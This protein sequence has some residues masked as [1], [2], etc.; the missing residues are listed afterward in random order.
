[1]SAAQ[2]PSDNVSPPT[3][4]SRSVPPFLDL[5]WDDF[6][7]LCRDIALTSGCR[8]VRRHGK[9]GQ[10]QDGIDFHGVDLE[11][12]RIAWQC[13]R[14]GKFGAS[15]L[16]RAVGDFAE[17]PTARQYASFVICIACEGNDRNLQDELTSLRELHQFKI[18]LWDS[19]FLTTKLVRL[20]DLLQ[21][22]F[23]EHWTE[24]LIASAATARVRLN[25][26]ALL[27]GPV[28]A[29]G[30]TSKA[31]QADRL[32]ES[33]PA[34]AVRLYGETERKLR[35]RF[36]RHADRFLEKRAFALIDA[37]G[38]EAGH[39]EFMRLAVRDLFDRAGHR[40][41][42]EVERGLDTLR[43]QLDPVRRARAEALF[44]FRWT[45][46]H[47]ESLCDL[48]G[49][50]DAL[51]SDDQYA[52]HIAVLLTEVAVATR[53]H[54]VVN[55]RRPRLEQTAERADGDL[56]LRLRLA[57]ADA[58]DADS[59]LSLIADAQ[60]HRFRP[61]EATFI[62][63]R[64]A[65]WSAWSGDGER[66]ESLYRQAMTHGAEAGLDLDVKNA[67]RSLLSLN[68]LFDRYEDFDEAHRLMLTLDGKDS[69]IPLST[70]TARYSYQDLATGDLVEAHLLTRYRVL[71]GVRSGCLS[72]ELEARG[73]LA[74]IYLASDEPIDAIEQAVLGGHQ[75]LTEEAASRI[76][77]W[78]EFLD[79]LVDTS[80]PWARPTAL[81]ALAHLGDRC[82]PSMATRLAEGLIREICAEPEDLLLG[83]WLY[84]GLGAVVL[85]AT[86]Q[87]LEKL[88]PVMTQAASREPQEY[89]LTDP[90]VV[91]VALLLYR[92]RP[93]SRGQAAKVLAERLIGARTRD[94]WRA[95]RECGPETE[96]LIKAIESV[97]ARTGVNLDVALAKLEHL[98]ES[99][100]AHWSERMKYVA[101]HPTGPMRSQTIGDD[102]EVAKPFLEG[103]TTEAVTEYVNKLV[104]MAN[105]SH[106]H[107]AN[108]DG[109]LRAGGNVVDL[110]PTDRRI[111]LFEQVRH[112]VEPD[113]E[114][115][116]HEQRYAESDHPLSRVRIGL[117][118]VTG[119]RLAAGWFLV[120]SAA[121][122]EQ[123]A[124]AISLATDWL[125]SDEQR[126]QSH[127]ALLLAQPN[128]A[129]HLVRSAELAKHT[130]PAVRRMAPLMPDAKAA[131]DLDL[132]RQ[133]ATDSS[134]DVRLSVIDALPSCELDV[135]RQLLSILAEDPSAIVRRA[136]AD[137]A[138]DE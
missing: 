1:M 107:A 103:Q 104:A 46:E 75:E 76:D 16:R 51:P 130:N 42:P 114:L 11:D 8:D 90:G 14:V 43:D 78:P 48:A 3:V 21:R 127:G 101:E 39:D 123:R 116:E 137:A 55:D 70:Q 102:Y 126:F 117:G 132:L 5:H 26:D 106:V 13:K 35:E 96:T 115:S 64:A 87:D 20:P 54:R 65:R 36:P 7:Q 15:E 72:E 57:L 67:L 25:A 45:H 41:S 30:L 28:E 23:G 88:I 95:I 112:L 66:A 32:L 99:T 71:E 4:T 59:W 85:E 73:V 24:R 38:A 122:R 124:I 47:P 29:Y 81:L 44:E 98:S 94:W 82:T 135:R 111:S 108:R 56:A 74:R 19:P 100:R 89:S 69:F 10:K 37:V 9:P 118:G 79:A 63:M 17:G 133:L 22:Y 2:D 113:V 12:E 105:S 134:R 97:A 84:E 58:S 121:S 109:A 92:F 6:E 53:S 33:S 40:L 50:F 77:N 125:R 61:R 31:E 60:A 119:L 34:D 129:D 62:C 83:Q 110:L 136:T 49:C 80:A 52:A 91:T 93:Q 120:R 27:L 131:P 18:E 138:A 86:E 68:G 128:L